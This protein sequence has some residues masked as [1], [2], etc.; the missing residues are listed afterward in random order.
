MSAAAWK[1][2]PDVLLLV[3]HAI[4][5]DVTY[6]DLCEMDQSCCVHGLSERH[7]AASAS[8]VLISPSGIAHI[9]Q[10]PHKGDDPDY[11]RWA[12]IDTPDAWQRLGNGE[13]VRATGGSCPDLIAKARCR[14]C[15]DHGPW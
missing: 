8:T 12:E 10:C 15:V 9:P 4:M 5:D 1:P 13:H 11:S 7:R 14:D 3:L 6:C 2:V